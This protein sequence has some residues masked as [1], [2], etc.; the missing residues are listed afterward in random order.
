MIVISDTSPL[1]N[2]AAI[3][4]LELI[5]TL[6]EQIIIPPAVY[7]EIIEKA[8][9]CRAPPKSKMLSGRPLGLALT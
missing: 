3:G 6:F 4:H 7:H 9:A 5:P 1:I 8:M 2:L